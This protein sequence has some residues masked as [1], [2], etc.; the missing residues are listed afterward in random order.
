M[1]NGK[2]QSFAAQQ[3]ANQHV[4]QSSN[5]MISRVSPKALSELIPEF[6][7]ISNLDTQFVKNQVFF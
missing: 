2:P 1:E 3:G 7:H 5:Q 6:L 4:V